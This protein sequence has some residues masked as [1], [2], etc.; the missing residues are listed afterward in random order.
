MDVNQASKKWGISAST[1]RK[2][3]ADRIIPPAEKEGV[4]SKWSI[5]DEWPRPPMGRHRLCYLL[6]TIY[7]LKS[8]VDYS[9]IKWGVAGND[10]V[11]GFDYLM[12]AAFMSTI[13][14]SN[15]EHELRHAIVTPRGQQLI[16][17]D[18][19]AIDGKTR[20]STHI[21]AEAGIGLAKVNIGGEISN[22]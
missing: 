16:E 10:V 15:L 8:G 11:A 5:P 17:T 9:A 18:N 20:Y 14:T 6:D 13:D 19:R 4:S 22:G 2:Y 21:N 3:C 12:S 7:Q 1:V